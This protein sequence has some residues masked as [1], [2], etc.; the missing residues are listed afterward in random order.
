MARESLRQT[1]DRELVG[2]IIR[3]EEVLNRELEEAANEFFIE[4]ERENEMIEELRALRRSPYP[5]QLRQNL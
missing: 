2:R 1:R 4:Q 5:R 3:E